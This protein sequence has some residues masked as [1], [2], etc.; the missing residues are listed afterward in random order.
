MLAVCA[1][2]ALAWFA[3]GPAPGADLDG[4]A[5]RRAAYRDTF[6]AGSGREIAER[7]CTSCHSPMLVTQQAKDSTG[8]EK[9]VTL[10]ERWG[11]PFG[12][13]ERDTLAAYLRAA[14]PPRAERT[15]K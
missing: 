14:F 6:P 5:R 15:T 8:W 12:R 9:T 13:H 3:G 1:G 7:S 2:I 10:M 11:A 4:K